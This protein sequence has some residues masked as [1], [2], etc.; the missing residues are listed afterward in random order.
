MAALAI[1][2]LTGDKLNGDAR[3]GSEAF[4]YPT[5]RRFTVACK[6]ERHKIKAGQ[7]ARPPSLFTYVAADGA[8]GKGYLRHNAA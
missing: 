8:D 4:H 7:F 6:R 2:P 5:V 3:F 1:C